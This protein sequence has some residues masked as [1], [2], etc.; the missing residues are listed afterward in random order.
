METDQTVIEWE[1]DG[2]HGRTWGTDEYLSTREEAIVDYGG[3][4][5]VTPSEETQVLQT[6]GTRSVANVIVNP[7]PSNYGRIAWDG[8]GIMVY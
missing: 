8:I 3:P 7:I 4:Y 5:E 1:L 6:E 2:D